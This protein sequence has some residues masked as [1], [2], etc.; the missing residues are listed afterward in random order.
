M[1]TSKFVT[2]ITFRYGRSISGTLPSGGD[3]KQENELLIQDTDSD[4]NPQQK[5]RS[6]RSYNYRCEVDYQ[7][8]FSLLPVLGLLHHYHLY[9][10][11]LPHPIHHRVQAIVLRD[12]RD[13][14]HWLH[15]GLLLPARHLDQVQNYLLRHQHP[16]KQHQW[17][18]LNH[19]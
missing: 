9:L 18:G 19:W 5:G 15:S 8:K 6:N 3:A 4:E 12:I 13:R 10:R 1:T 14:D 7:G 11:L 2:E 16:T 17:L